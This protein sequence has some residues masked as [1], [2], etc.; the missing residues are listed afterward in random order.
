M[1]EFNMAVEP[2]LVDIPDALEPLI[3]AEPPVEDD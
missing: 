3:A 1:E 2:E